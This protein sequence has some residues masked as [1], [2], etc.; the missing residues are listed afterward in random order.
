M[1]RPTPRSCLGW[2][3]HEVYTSGCFF[4][5]ITHEPSRPGHDD[6][7]ASTAR[8]V[9]FSSVPCCYY[10]SQRQCK[11][12]P[13]HML[14]GP[15]RKIKERWRRMHAYIHTC[16]LTVLSSVYYYPV[17]H[18][19]RNPRSSHKCCMDPVLCKAVQQSPLIQ[20]AYWWDDNS[21]DDDSRVG[22]AG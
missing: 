13:E 18:V 8:R 5:E 19:Q 14:C 21:S 7:D 15:L 2:P 1:L 12:S 9:F 16:A 20:A 4:D 6:L 11:F 10:Q 3:A 17:S 22:E